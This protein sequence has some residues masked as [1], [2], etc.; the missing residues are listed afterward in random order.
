MKTTSR[1]TSLLSTRVNPR[2]AAR[3][4]ALVV[5]AL[6]ICLA[7]LVAGV[8]AQPA[9]AA[10]V[11][12][13]ASA[14]ASADNVNT[15]SFSHTTGTGSERLMLVGV[16]WNS[17]NAARTISS[18]T[19]TPS[20]GSAEDLGAAVIR[21]QAGT[22]LRYSAIY[23]WLSP[24]SGVSGTVTISFSDVVGN[25]IVADAANF[26]GVNQTTPLGTAVGA[27]T[28]STSSKT[29]SVNVTGL[30]GDE[31]VFDNVFA[32]AAAATQTLAPAS[33]SGQTQL[34]S[35]LR[36]ASSPASNI[37]AG[38]SI[39][40][41]TTSSL[42]MSWTLFSAAY[43]AIA[44]VPIKPA[45]TGPTQVLT[46]AVAPPG[47]G[48]TSPSVGTHTIPQG[49]TVTVTATPSAG[50][51]FDY[52]EGDVADIHAPSTTV[53]M[54]ADKAVTAHFVTRTLT[55]GVAPPGGG[56]TSPTAGTHNY[57][58]DQVVDI[59]ATPS[60][61]YRFDHWSGD[62][63][64]SANPVTVTMGADKTVT[65]NFVAEEYSLTVDIAGQGAVI[66]E[67]DLP[68]YHYG[69]QVT[70][71]AIPA[72]GCEFAGWSGGLT[73]GL[74]PQNVTIDADKT[75]TAHFLGSVVHL[76]G[77]VSSNAA[78]TGGSLSVAHTTGSGTNRLLLVGVS[79]NCGSTDRTIS[80]VK[81]TPTGGSAID[82]GSPVIKQQAG[83]Q[84]RYSAIFSLVDPPA[85][86]AGSI[87]VTFSDSVSNGIVVGAANFKG[88][89]QTTPL[90]T[91][92]GE[93]S[94]AQGTAASVTL[95][96]LAGDELVF[97]NLFL[98]YSSSQTSLT[99][100][101][102]QTQQWSA[103]TSTSSNVWG[104][105]STEQA[106]VSSVTMSWTAAYNAYWAIAAVPI[107]PAPAV[108]THDLTVNVVGGG[109]VAKDPAPPYH[110][111]DEVELT[112][113]ADPGWT[114]SGWSGDA[115]GSANP[116]TVT[117]DGDKTV[118]ATF[119][120]N[121]YALTVNVVG[122]GA[123]AKDPDPPY[124]YGDEVEL[125]AT[126]DPGW[127]FSGWS[128]DASGSA[129]P[130][131]VTMDADKTVT[132]TFTQNVYALT[133][134]V[135]GNG[136][137]AKNPDQ[138]TYHYGDTVELTATP[139]LGWSF[140]YWD[141]DVADPGAASTTLTVD[142]DETV[143]AY[144]FQDEYTL[145][146][147]VVGNGAVAKNPDQA[148]YHYGDEVEL[149]AT[150]DP[151]WTFSGWSGDASGSANPTT[152]TM[153]ADK[154]VTAHFALGFT[155]IAVTAPSSTTDKAQGEDLDVA[156][157]TNAAVSD[158]EFSIWVVDAGYS[159]WYVGKTHAA[160]GRTDPY[161]DKVKLDVPPGDGYH[162]FVYYR[163]S[164]SDPWGIYAYTAG[165]VNVST[166]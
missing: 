21:Q 123:V 27:P 127:T 3:T 70:L 57:V 18:V 166:P 122:G 105:A 38:A 80:S 39:K 59:T 54:G 120:Q 149:T 88:V 125:T 158:G 139:D 126:A 24:P 45:P 52:W 79:W 156:W 41:A 107:N 58:P 151:G 12:E 90:G 35:I 154:T 10:V 7:A 87:A 55:I 119:T 104:A 31:M 103:H 140:N 93:G 134:N 76:D 74:N 96:G 68:S 34:W 83:T 19:F 112:A 95:D 165:L 56:T 133:V 94:T 63:T 2:K 132:A 111:G 73:G 98:G 144:F 148:T 136:A 131:T 16:S 43:W 102:G 33:G 4:P 130:T 20:G 29:P 160:D 65:A 60:P 13:G 159:S 115:S 50:Y 86:Q 15:I 108:L 155:S 114:F 101:P 6:L 164:G 62:A 113:T 9:V 142:G 42:T 30:V 161:T 82:L 49:D 72:V 137:V 77:S 67:P 100:G 150:A 128:G 116:T 97:D 8:S 157:T 32:G 23:K 92:K 64:G 163:A 81:F 162:V 51:A 129:S 5:V 147:N 48:T 99:V 84:L 153:D 118:T 37:I 47:G 44:A 40:Q 25:G 53:T 135:G 71:T 22:Q 46:M 91:P 143:T 61:G 146:A 75:V 85:N 124:H 36:F 145:T 66:R 89:D 28:T 121:V 110:Y 138:A 17:G 109:A 152:V 26:A 14:G 117:M 11:F 69:D 106:I 78:D 141:G 1:A